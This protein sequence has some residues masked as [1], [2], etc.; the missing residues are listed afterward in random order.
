MTKGSGD[1]ADATSQRS[2][3]ARV[4]TLETCPDFRKVTA[5]LR[6]L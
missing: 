3:T 1:P 6:P 4:L 2:L 5:L